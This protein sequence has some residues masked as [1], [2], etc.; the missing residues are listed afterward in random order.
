MK[1]K[2]LL[3]LKLQLCNFNVIQLFSDSNKVQE[4]IMLE[5]LKNTWSRISKITPWATMFGS[6]DSSNDIDQ[7]D[8]GDCYFLGGA[9]S[10]AEDDQRFKQIFV[11][12]LN[13][14]AGI[15]TIIT[16][17]DYLPVTTSGTKSIFAQI[18]KDGSMW[19]SLL[20]KAW[21]KLNGNYERIGGGFG[22][23]PVSFLTNSPSRFYKVAG[24]SLDALWNLVDDSDTNEF[25]MTVSTAPGSDKDKCIF[26]LPCGH[27]FTLL[28][29]QNLISKNGTKVIR[30]YKF[31]NP[32]KKDNS[33]TGNW[34]DSS[35]I[36][37]ANGETY[38]KQVNLT[39]ADDGIMWVEES[40]FVKAFNQL[41]VSHYQ[42]NWEFSWY[43]KEDDN[44]QKA[45]YYFKL[46]KTTQLIIKLDIYSSR[47]YAFN[48]KTL[49][50]D[51]TSLDLRLVS[52]DSAGK[53]LN[54]F[55]YKSLSSMDS[56]GWINQTENPLKPGQYRVEVTPTW[57]QSDVKDYTV[58]IHAPYKI[59]LTDSK[60]KTNQVGG[61]HDL[62]YKLSENKANTQKAKSNLFQTKKE[63]TEH[64]RRDNSN[65]SFV[66]YSKH[67][68]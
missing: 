8:V 58:V 66:N 50:D 11:N 32:W 10:V 46:D 37:N 1:C 57:L 38:D 67:K 35:P 4:K 43:N 17:D 56:F 65:I 20:E 62:D 5:Y 6:Q 59:Q 16:V 30:M 51:D 15:P 52:I 22:Q 27:L 18:G 64:K 45:L 44:G 21:A 48:C 13:N 7:G 53:I 28:D 41:E 3:A 23:E 54:Q 39:I 9:A 49:G 36:W 42:K 34:K 55:S 19:V 63:A 60:G 26:N 33:F 12:E 14:K 31:R 2:L 61:S 68:E 29:A 25:L 24:L 47:M 40:E